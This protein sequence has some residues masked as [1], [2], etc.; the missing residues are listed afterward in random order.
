MGRRDCDGENEED[1]DNDDD[2]D[3]DDD[4]DHKRMIGSEKACKE[5]HINKMFTVVPGF[6]GGDF[7]Y[8]CFSHTLPKT[9]FW[10]PPSPGTI[11]QIC[12]C[13]RVFLSLK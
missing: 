12:F 13:L 5:K 9:A 11:L 7:A 1:E 3:D 10:H 8:V 2:D 4:D 6:L